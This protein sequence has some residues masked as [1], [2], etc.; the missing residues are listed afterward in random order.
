MQSP[1]VASTLLLLLRLYSSFD[2]YVSKGINLS[3][4][5]YKNLVE[6]FSQKTY[7]FFDCITSPY[8]LSHVNI[9]ASSSA[10]PHWYYLPDQNT[11][12][13]WKLDTTIESIMNSENKGVPLPVLSMEVV[14]NDRVVYD[15]T[16][17]SQ[18]IKVYPRIEGVFPSP[19]HILGAWSF[20][21]GIVLDRNRDFILRILDTNAE[22]KEA[23][24]YD[25]DYIYETCKL[26]TDDDVEGI[27]EAE[28]ETSEDLSGNLLNPL[29]E[30]ATT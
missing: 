11:F 22:E 3:Y 1:Y 13:G 9:S 27:P 2:D 25:C 12:V 29:Q 5:V 23:E 30:E 20:S 10:V 21:S 6:A 24:I 18:S 26:E 7:V 14:E 19:A 28:I 4:T 8:N 16:D 17:F 15:L